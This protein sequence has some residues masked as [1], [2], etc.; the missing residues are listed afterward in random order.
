ML[1]TTQY[2]YRKGL[3]IVIHFVCFSAAF[4]RVDPQV[5]ELPYEYTIIRMVTP[6][7]FRVP[8]PMN[9]V[10]V[11]ESLIHDLCWVS[12]WCDL[13]GMKLNMSKTKTMIFS[14]SCTKHPQSSPLMIGGT[15][16]K[17][18]DDLDILGV[19]FDPKMTFVK[20]LCSISREASN[21]WYLEEDLESIP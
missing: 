1:P 15:V 21:T 11:S 16:L 4:D 17:E 20:Y 5:S 19:T 13:W 3:G 7:A 10:K 6:Q 8:S 12:Q 2:A 18:S 9:R 14:N